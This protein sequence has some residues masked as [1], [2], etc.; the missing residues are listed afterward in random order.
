MAQLSRH[1]HDAWSFLSRVVRHRQMVV[2]VLGVVLG[3]LAA[4]AA[5]AFR[6]LIGLIQLGAFGFDSERLFSLAQELP[7]WH[8]LLV[9]ALGGLVVGLF[10]SPVYRL[11]VTNIALRPGAEVFPTL[12][13]IDRLYPPLGLERTFPIPVELTRE[14]LE[15]ALAGSGIPRGPAVWFVGDAAIDVECARNAGCTAVQMGEAQ[16]E[17]AGITAPRPDRWISGCSAFAALVRDP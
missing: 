1:F 9:P 13:I 12:E 4:G 10:I 8:I 5:I 15:L 2:F 17:M 16:P 3:A 7:W 6:H 11:K 14:E